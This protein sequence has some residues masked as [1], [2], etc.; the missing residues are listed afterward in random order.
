MIKSDFDDHLGSPTV[1]L[2][3]NYDTN[4]TTTFGVV[5]QETHHR[6]TRTEG[7]SIHPVKSC[8]RRNLSSQSHYW[9]CCTG[10]WLEHATYVGHMCTVSTLPNVVFFLVILVIPRYSNIFERFIQILGFSRV[11]LCYSFMAQPW[12]TLKIEIE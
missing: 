2:I 6:L 8:Q 4:K 12:C 3:T 10:C 9:H 1:I 5:D 11:L 7:W